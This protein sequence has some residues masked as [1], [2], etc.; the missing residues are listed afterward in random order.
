MP[1]SLDPVRP[2]EIRSLPFPT[3]F[4]TTPRRPAP[5][6]P[7][8]VRAASPVRARS[9]GTGA[10]PPGETPMTQAQIDRAVAIQTGEPLSVIR[11]LGFSLLIEP[12]EEPAADDIRLV[13]HCPFCGDQVPYPGRSRDGS[14]ALA[15]CPGCDVYF[16][17][18]DR[19][20]FPA[21]ARRVA[22][23]STARHRYI[24]A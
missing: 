3:Q 16:E 20:V 19:D 13:V 11:R 12:R 17:F 14:Q 8:L 22:D 23:P 4:P 24:P 2:S 6:C 5:P 9:R 18:E 10:G 15:E 1:E 21:S 7:P